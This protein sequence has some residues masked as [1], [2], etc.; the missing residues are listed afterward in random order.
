MEFLITFLVLIH[1]TFGI[2]SVGIFI[3]MEN[4]F[5]DEENFPSLTSQRFKIF[6]FIICGIFTFIPLLLVA[7]SLQQRDLYNFTFE[8]K[9]KNKNHG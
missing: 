1:I 7:L 2:F 4:N 3:S 8:F 9:L 5:Y 6:L